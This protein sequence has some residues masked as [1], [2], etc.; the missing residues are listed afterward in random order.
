MA[1]QKYVSAEWVHDEIMDTYTIRAVGDDDSV[2]FIPALD[3]DVP[4]WPDYLKDGGEVT[5]TGPPP[6]PETKPA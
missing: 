4:P 5:G 6:P 1:L 3:C 2:W